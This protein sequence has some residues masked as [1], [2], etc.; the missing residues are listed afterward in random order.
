MMTCIVCGKKAAKEVVSKHT[1]FQ[2]GHEE[3]YERREYEC[4]A[5]HE[6]FTNDEQGASNEAA[7]RRATA[8]ALATIGADELKLLREL[9]GLTQVELEN[10]IGL[11]RN[12]IARWETGGRQLP[13]YIKTMVRLLALNPEAL[14]L[15]RDQ[16]LPASE[17]IELPMGGTLKAKAT[18]S[19]GGRSAAA[20]FNVSAEADFGNTDNVIRLRIP[21]TKKSWPGAAAA[22]VLT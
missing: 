17:R 2:L 7:E 10:V 19:Y 1:V 9:A 8:R 22:E 18:V 6:T 3:S 13:A 21:A 16:D 20:E 11:G 4:K 14:M 5:C 15:L 12:T